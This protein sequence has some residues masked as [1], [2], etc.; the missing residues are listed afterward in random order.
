MFFNFFF[1]SRRRHTS[2]LCDWSSDVCS[3]D[4]VG[5]AVLKGPTEA[6][7]AW[8]ELPASA[9]GTARAYEGLLD[10]MVADERVEALPALEMDTRMDDA[11]G[12]RRVAADVL[13]FAES[14]S[15]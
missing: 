12:R 15:P 9:A 10:G 13:R 8:A 3:S 7:M 4:L 6:F 5:G 1:S 14:L 11:A 2:S